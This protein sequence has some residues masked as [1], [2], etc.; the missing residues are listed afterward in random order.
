M[1]K[2]L[3]LLMLPYYFKKVMRTKIN[4]IILLINKN[5]CDICPAYTPQYSLKY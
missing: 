5:N 2:V 1:V 3:T 4:T